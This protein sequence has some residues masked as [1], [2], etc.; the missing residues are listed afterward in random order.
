MRP[1]DFQVRDITLFANHLS[2]PSYKAALMLTLC[3]VE[4]VYRVIDITTPNFIGLEGNK[5]ADLLEINPFGRVPA[6]RH[7]TLG[8]VESNVILSYLADET[9]R[10]GGE[11]RVARLRIQE[12][13]AFESSQL[14]RGFAGARANMKFLDGAPAV[15]EAFQSEARIALTLLDRQLTTTPFLI[16]EKA[17]IA[18]ISTYAIARYA[19]EIDLALS[20]WPNVQVWTGR[21]KALPR[22]AHPEALLPVS[23]NTAGI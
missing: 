5:P 18:D 9:G 4:F 12:W 11:G 1:T 14:F 23:G 7:G 13:L 20:D 2:M 8:I 17:T 19:H 22:F 10:F 6:L 16:G 21:M 15:I 3:E